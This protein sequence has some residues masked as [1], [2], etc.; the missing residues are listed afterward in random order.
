MRK[1]ISLSGSNYMQQVYLSLVILI[2][3]YYFIFKRDILN[4]VEIFWYVFKMWPEINLRG[5]RHYSASSVS[6]DLLKCYKWTRNELLPGG[7]LPF[8]CDT[9]SHANNLKLYKVWSVPA[10]VTN[11]RKVIFYPSN[12]LVN[13]TFDNPIFRIN[14][15]K[16][17]CTV[18]NLW[19]CIAVR[20]HCFMKSRCVLLPCGNPLI[21]LH[22]IETITI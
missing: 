5:E 8:R 18:N 17:L 21:S 2:Y 20:E 13:R 3:E 9:F 22:V 7:I 6:L 16:E 12:V 1:C 10:M 14:P 4:K 19:R 15:G 11:F